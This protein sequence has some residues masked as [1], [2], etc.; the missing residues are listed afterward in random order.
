MQVS[1]NPD[2]KVGALAGKVASLDGAMGKAGTSMK[3]FG[4]KASEA[5]TG[6]IDKVGE[7]AWHWGKIGALAAGAALT[8]GVVGLNQEL[9]NTN[10]ALGA[11][12]KAQG[13][14]DNFNDGLVMAADTVA[15]MK[16]DVKV[17]PGDLGQLAGIFKSISTPAAQAGASIDTIRKVAG[18]T[19]IVG[20]VMGLDSGMAAREMAMLLSGRAGAHNV[21]GSRLG[22]MGESAKELNAM[23]PEKRLEKVQGELSKYQP[24]MDA[25]GKSFVGMFTTLKDNIKYTFLTNLS[26]PLFESVKVAL[27]RVNGWFD[28]NG[29]RVETWALVTGDKIAAGFNMGVSAVERWYPAVKDF[30]VNAYQEIANI[31]EKV[32]PIVARVGESIRGFLSDPASIG[33][34]EHIL[35]LYG[36]V[37]I[38][39]AVAGFLGPLAGAVSAFG[40]AGGAAAAAGGGEAAAATVAA[41]GIGIAAG[42]AIVPL[43]LMAMAIYGAT[44][45]VNDSSAFMHTT[46]VERWGLVKSDFASM[47]GDLEQSVTSVAPAFMNVADLMGTT[48]LW[49]LQQLTN[50]LQDFTYVANY[51]IQSL[52]GARLNKTPDEKADHD[53]DYFQGAYGQAIQAQAQGVTKAVGELKNAKRHPGGAGINI[54][55]LEMT[56]S[57]NDNADRVAFLV[58]DKLQNLR[59]HPRA[60]PDSPNYSAANP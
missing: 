34:L 5:F 57:S 13:F 18:Q 7:F 22:F 37:K 33:K 54:A 59:R 39:G 23:S 55:K 40:G 35:E 32:E 26:S 36:A 60:S 51:A 42:E 47:T 12:F 17:L 2:A 14:A 1:G 28:Q 19:M 9:E 46:A 53:T 6:A 11:I 49:A 45:A 29:S 41:G 15:K 8:Y 48:M 50:Q 21:L 25:Y 31:W 44:D 24:A 56:V 27:G 3:E 58:L 43:G 16:Q 4:A 10:I 30:A 20:G 38:G 52:F